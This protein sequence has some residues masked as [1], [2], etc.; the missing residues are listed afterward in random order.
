MARRAYAPPLRIGPPIVGDEAYGL[1]LLMLLRRRAVS[2]AGG[3][4][5]GVVLE[6][7]AIHGCRSNGRWPSIGTTAGAVTIQ[8]QVS[9]GRGRLVFEVPGQ[10]RLGYRL[11]GL[12]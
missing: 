5:M 8:V 3:I 4:G 11:D 6:M 2:L 9:T 10:N 7:L 12:A 1:Q